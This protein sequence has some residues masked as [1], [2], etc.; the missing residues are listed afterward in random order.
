MKGSESVQPVGGHMSK[1]GDRA[2]DL[3]GGGDGEQHVRWPPEGASAAERNRDRPA[4]CF[5]C[6][7][8]DRPAP[9][10]LRPWHGPPRRS[11]CLRPLRAHFAPS[12]SG[13]HEAAAPFGRRLAQWLGLVL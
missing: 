7:Q 8:R 10:Q 1:N 3:I 5:R 12:T 9:L 13:H 2:A 6:G 11:D 4:S